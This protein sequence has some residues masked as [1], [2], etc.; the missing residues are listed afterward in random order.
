MRTRSLGVLAL[1]LTPILCLALA[2]C[3]SD[4]VHARDE[5]RSAN[6]MAPVTS[7]RADIVAFLHTYLNN[8]I[9]VRDAYI[10]EPALRTV[11]GASRNS[12]CLRYTARKSDGQYGPSKDSLVIFRQGRLDRVVDNAREACKDVAYQPFPELE[13]MTR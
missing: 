5:A 12:V 4:W 10:S 13:H 9:G 7:Y 6:T 8:P 3:N 1:S 2:G 11:E